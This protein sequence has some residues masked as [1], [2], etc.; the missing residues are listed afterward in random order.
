[1]DFLANPPSEHD[2]AGQ[3]GLNLPLHRETWIGRYRR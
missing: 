1:V 2:R 3:L